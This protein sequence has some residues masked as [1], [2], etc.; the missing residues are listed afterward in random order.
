[1]NSVTFW[2]AICAD[3][4]LSSSN[5]VARGYEANLVLMPTALP[6]V[7]NPAIKVNSNAMLTLPNAAEHM[8]GITSNVCVPC[9]SHA[10]PLFSI[11]NLS[12]VH[13]YS[14]LTSADGR[15]RHLAP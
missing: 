10:R 5:T 14:I 13:C 4:G 15:S 2:L 6:G 1:M 9:A 7:V 12:L 3:R 8:K 11:V